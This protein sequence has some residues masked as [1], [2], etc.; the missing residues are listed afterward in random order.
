MALLFKY[1]VV[2]ISMSNSN[3]RLSRWV[4]RSHVEPVGGE[5]T[6]FAEEYGGK[7]RVNV[8]RV[9]EGSFVNVFLDEY[10]VGFCREM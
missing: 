2:I 9:N 4:A 3:G 10:I 5:L 1:Y 8:A 7:N 6:K